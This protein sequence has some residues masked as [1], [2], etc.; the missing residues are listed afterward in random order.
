M[1]QCILCL[2]PAFEEPKENSRLVVFS[3]E[4]PVVPA[5]ELPVYLRKCSSY[6]KEHNVYLVPQRF[7]VDGVLYLCLFNPEGEIL[8][9]QGALHRNPSDQSHLDQ[10]GFVHVLETEVG[11][12]FLCVDRDIYSP[13]VLRLAKLKGAELIISSQYIE[14][15]ELKPTHITSGIWNAAQQQGVY[16]LGCCNAFSAVAAPWEISPDGS[17]FIIQPE[18]TRKLCCKLAFDRLEQAFM[19]GEIAEKLNSDFCKRYSHLLAQ[20]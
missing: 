1:A 4:R 13:E 14:K 20:D 18:F 16:V 3:D 17:G 2:T 19:G 10:Y 12:I 6:A 7:V 15:S 5:A 11:N 8:G 9:Y